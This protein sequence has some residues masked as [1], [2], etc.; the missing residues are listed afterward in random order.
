MNHREPGG[1]SAR[2]GHAG[3]WQRRLPP[4]LP[5]AP[6]PQTLKEQKHSSRIAPAQIGT[7]P[8]FAAAPKR[9]RPRSRSQP[10]ILVFLAQDPEAGA[11]CYSNANLRKGEEA[12]EIFRFISFWK[13]THGT[14]PRELVFD[15]RFTTHANLARLDRMPI[16]FITLRCRSPGLL[17]EI[18]QLP[19]SAWRV[20]ELDVPTRK[21]RTPRVFEQ[22]VTLAGCNFRQ[23]FIEDLGHDKPTILLANQ[24]RTTKQLILRY[25]QRML[26][27]NALSDA[28][29]FFH[30]D[31]LSSAVGMKV[32]FD[33]ALLVIASGLYRLLA[34]RMRGYSDA[35]A[36]QSFR[37]PRRY[38][39]R[40][41]HHPQ[42]SPSQL[43]SASSSAHHSCLRAD[44]PARP[45]PLVERISP[46]SHD[47]SGIT[48]NNSARLGQLLAV[49]IQASILA[50]VAADRVPRGLGLA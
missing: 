6:L 38:A 37:V 14:Y 48:P 10:S 41:N 36:R 16:A 39:G 24:Q 8:G 2:W 44:Q 50:V 33:M 43:S 20:V 19:A 5:P 25:A 1:P 18:A 17:K 29:R 3:E 26:I 46:A 40:R 23:L 32:D 30:I 34:R 35:Q 47:L 12:N 7:E 4:L 27:E 9:T 31:A 22:K 49:E 45:C 21:Y 42:G 15:S 28:V 11:F 13:R